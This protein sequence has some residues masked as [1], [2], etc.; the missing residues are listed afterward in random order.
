MTV[1]RPVVAFQI[2]GKDTQR[3]QEFYNQMFNWEIQPVMPGIAF[4]KV[5]PGGPP[6]PAGTILTGE[7][8]T[9]IFVQVANLGESLDK[10]VELGGKRVREPFDVPNGPTI[11]EIEDPEGNPVGLVQL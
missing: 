6:E 10:A 11:A 8:R 1:V 3:L 2:R 9:L 5:G 7:P 4:V